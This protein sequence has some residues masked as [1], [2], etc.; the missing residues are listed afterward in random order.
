MA[1]T[2]LRGAARRVLLASSALIALPG[3][4][5]AQAATS[6]LSMSLKGILPIAEMQG[7]SATATPPQADPSVV[8]SNPGTPSTILDQGVNGVGQ[9]I[10]DQKNGFV[11]LCTGTLINPRTVV[12]A[13]HCVNESPTGTAM[14]PWN[15][16]KG[17]GQLPIGFGFEADT[18][19]GQRA[20]FRS[21]YSTSTA[22]HFYNVNQVVYNAQSLNLGLANNFL[23]ADVALATFD[24]PAA[25]VPT[26]TM[27]FSPLP[28][29][30]SISDTTGTGYHVTVTGYGT[31]GT[32]LTGAS[33]AIDYRRRVAENY[34][35]LLG[36]IDDFYFGL[37]GGSAGLPAN[38]YQT[39]FDDPTRR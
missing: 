25:D 34:V 33:G 37:F 39:D 26:W 9:M 21:N 38:L 17:A 31:N 19:A 5:Q 2:A 32:G 18:I 24:T 23:Q 10:I 27:L 1:N 14:N 28:A 7:G 13:A 29:P 30:A 36:S 4:A 12:F 20:W 3:A 22:N 35:G 8:I 15:Y 11:G 16:G 6:D